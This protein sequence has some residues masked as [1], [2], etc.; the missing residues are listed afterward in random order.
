MGLIPPS[1]VADAVLELVRDDTAV[2]EERI[3]GPLPELPGA[4]VAGR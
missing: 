3:V 1:D 4:G 2:A